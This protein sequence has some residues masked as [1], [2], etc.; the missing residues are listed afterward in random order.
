MAFPPSVDILGLFPANRF[1]AADQVHPRGTR[2]WGGCD[3]LCCEVPGRAVD[4]PRALGRCG[5][6]LQ[7]LVRINLALDKLTLQFGYELLEIG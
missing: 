7:R 1:P 5:L 6:L 3:S 4:N 2:R